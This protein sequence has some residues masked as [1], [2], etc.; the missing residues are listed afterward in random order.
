MA[1]ACLALISPLLS[2]FQSQ[3][4]LQHAEEVGHA[5]GEPVG[6]S[7]VG[8]NFCSLS[9]IGTPLCDE[10]PLLPKSYSI[11]ARRYPSS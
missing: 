9:D 1:P 7:G 5:I 4:L 11:F 6:P 2:H 3:S 8:A 10:E